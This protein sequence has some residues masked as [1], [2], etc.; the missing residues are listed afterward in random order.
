MNMK[1]ILNTIFFLSVAVCFSQTTVG[2]GISILQGTQV[3]VLDNLNITSGHS[4]VNDGELVFKANITNNGAFTYSPSLNTGKLSFEG[5]D[6][7]ISGENLI[8][9][10]NV[11]FNNESTLLSGKLEVNNDA[12]FTS[13]IVNTQDFGGTLVFNELSD[14]LNTS[15]VSFVNGQVLRNGALDFVFPIGDT[16]FYRPIAISSLASFNVFSSSYTPENSNDLFPHAQKSTVIELIDNREYWELTR[17]EG[18]D[19]AVIEISRDPT[20]SSVEIMN[21]DLNALHIVRWDAERNFWLD[22]GGVVNTDNDAIRTVSNVKGYGIYALAIINTEVVLPGNV[23]VYNNLTPNGDGINDM[24]MIDGI[25]EFPDNKVQIFNRWGAVVYEVSGY[26]NK[27]KAFTGSANSGLSI[28]QGIL[29]S[30]T[31]YY[32]ILYTVDNQ[33]VRR[34]QFLYINGK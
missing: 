14:H 15:N 18:E 6:Q 4:V 17:T 7:E 11:L 23:I 30:G 9:S 12:D 5:S 33:V 21:A 31:Y 29:P 24:F 19:F 16:D 13:G 28:G 20:T 25:E 22:E 2:S 27:D 10:N 8:I 34:L 3:S 32:T 1:I 26:N